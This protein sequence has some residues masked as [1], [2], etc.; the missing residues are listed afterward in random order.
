MSDEQ[1]EKDVE[2]LRRT[3]PVEGESHT[4]EPEVEGHRLVRD[5]AERRAQ[6]S[7]ERRA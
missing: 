1:R 2:E 3:A 6:D 4:D 5:P 7:V